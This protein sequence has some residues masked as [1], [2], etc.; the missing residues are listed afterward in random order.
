MT[1]HRYLKELQILLEL[2]DEQ[3]GPGANRLEYKLQ[4]ELDHARRERPGDAPERVVGA[5]RVGQREV[6][7]VQEIEELAAELDLLVLPPQRKRLVEAEVGRVQRI[8]PRDIAPRVAEGIR[9]IGRNRDV[10]LVEK[11]VVDLL[12]AGGIDRA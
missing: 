9:R 12:A 3:H 5:V 4:R 8:S 1:E 7:L 11:V 2:L 10:V 6:S